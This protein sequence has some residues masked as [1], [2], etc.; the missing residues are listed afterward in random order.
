MGSR[1]KGKPAKDGEP[2]K[3][4]TFNDVATSFVNTVYALVFGLKGRTGG[5]QDYGADGLFVCAVEAL[6]TARATK[7]LEDFLKSAAYATAAAMKAS[8]TWDY[9]MAEP[10]AAKKEDEEEKG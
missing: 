8:G 4:V 5:A 1:K 9:P 3:N 10:R 2:D 6:H 7:N